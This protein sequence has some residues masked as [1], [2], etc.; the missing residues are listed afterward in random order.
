MVLAFPFLIVSQNGEWNSLS[1]LGGAVSAEAANSADADGIAAAGMALFVIFRIFLAVGGTTLI[2]Y[3]NSVIAK[4]DE[5]DR[6]KHMTINQF[7]FNG[8]AFVANIFFVIPGASAA[9]TGSP[10]A[11]TGILATFVVLV[12]AILVMYIMFGTEIVPKTTKANMAVATENQVT[13]GKVLKEKDT[14]TLISFFIVWLIAVVFVNSS[15]MRSFLEQSPA[16]FRALAIAHAVDPSVTSIGNSQW[17]WVWPAFISFFV[18]GFFVGPA[19]LAGFGKTIFERKFF[20]IFMLVFGYIFM[21]LSL[22]VGYFGG[23]DNA[24]ALAFMLIFIFMSGF[25]LWSVQPPVLTIPQQLMKSN[26]KYVGI[27][28]GLIWGV[29]YFGYTIGEIV[30]SLLVSYVGPFNNFNGSFVATGE[31]IIANYGAAG[32]TT[33]DHAAAA[34]AYDQMVANGVASLNMKLSE[35]SGTIAMFVVFWVLLFAAIP[36]TFLLPRAGYRNKNNEFIEFTQKWQ[37]FKNFGHFNVKN[38]AYLISTH[39]K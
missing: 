6:P 30:M 19:T 32:A 27:V 2:T 29:G 24:A 28:A 38:P 21:M 18:A 1:V 16:N 10:A 25:F 4:M 37:P 8:G 20:I 17:Y 9:I 22:L 39:N 31:Y 11:W 26:A 13:F 35:T 23:Y 3:T 12:F 34:T 7:G 36:L 15:T 33:V 5:K 14:W